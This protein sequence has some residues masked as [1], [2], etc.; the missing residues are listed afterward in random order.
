MKDLGPAIPKE[1]RKSMF[2]VSLIWVKGIA[3]IYQ[4]LPASVLREI[5][6]YSDNRQI[7]DVHDG[8]L[9]VDGLETRV[10]VRSFLSVKEK[11]RPP[12][13]VV[14]GAAYLFSC[15]PSRKA[16]VGT[17]TYHINSLGREERLA[18]S[19][20]PGLGSPGPLYDDDKGYYYLFGGITKSKKLNTIQ[21][22]DP[23]S[24]TKT[25]IKATL[26][27]S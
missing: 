18:D 3:A 20:L 14:K 2:G 24:N 15:G 9:F 1:Q 22:Y 23:K 21:V 26:C 12:L 6:E 4:K 19:L 10:W 7:M 27:I 8:M 13:L 16:Y 25:Q 17:G 11:D 5:C